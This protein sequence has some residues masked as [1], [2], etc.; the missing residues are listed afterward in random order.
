MSGKD[1]T[2]SNQR[3]ARAVCIVG[4][5][6]DGL[7]LL[8]MLL[9][10]LG[11]KLFGLQAFSPGPDYRYAMNVAAS[12]MLGWTLL[13]FWAS[14]RPTERA[15]VLLLTA[16]VVAGLML[17]GF[18]AVY[19][20]FVSLRN[21]LPV[22]VIQSSLVALFLTGYKKASQPNQGSREDGGE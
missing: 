12:L 22:F 14:R 15:A 1:E 8:P 21:M 20:G 18:C 2:E 9:P 7:M 17:A 6:F 3:F 19:S 4:G 11:G 10:D 16:I 5:V 13:L